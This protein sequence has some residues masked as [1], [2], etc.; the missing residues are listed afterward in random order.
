LFNDRVEQIARLPV[1]EL[2]DRLKEFEGV[3]TVV[4]DGIITQRLVDIASEK[5]IKYLIAARI[6]DLVK[7]PLNISLLTFD[8]ILE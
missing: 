7:Q 4:F 6:S 5:N 2:A 3:N 1:S 8:D